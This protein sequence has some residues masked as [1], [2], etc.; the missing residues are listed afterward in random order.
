[1]PT[2]HFPDRQGSP[3]D[4]EPPSLR[5]C[6]CIIM[7][8]GKMNNVRTRLRSALITAAFVGLSAQTTL[9]QQAPAATVVRTVL[10]VTS[11]PSVV[12]ASVFFKLS[13]IE[14]T[15]GQTTRYFGPVGFLYILSG[16]LAVQSDAGQ[17]SLQQDDAFLVAA[18]NPHSLSASGPQAAQFLH[19]V[20]ARSSELEQAV[21]QPP[22]VVT[23]LYRTP[24][25]IPDLKP[26]RYEFTL[27]RVSYPRMDPNPPHYRSGA[28]LY[29]VRSGSGIFIADGKIETKE[30]GIAHFEP[31]GW[32]HQW[33]NSAD[34]PLVLLQANISE[35]GIPAVIMRQPPPSGT[36]R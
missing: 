7:M 21:E 28:A 19:F 30:T 33:A 23:E 6:Q 10:A 34:A 4:R 5:T 15:A 3:I 22:A 31:H 2:T 32:V 14:L 13:K 24:R 17:R 29:Y 26:G 27:T 20:L 36:G 11:L 8:V 12:D 1:M 35:E 16:A 9:A 25:A 18:G